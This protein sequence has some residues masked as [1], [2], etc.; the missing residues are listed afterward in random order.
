MDKADFRIPKSLHTVNNASDLVLSNQQQG[1]LTDI[2]SQ[3]GFSSE[4]ARH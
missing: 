1:Q 2:M 3:F 4:V